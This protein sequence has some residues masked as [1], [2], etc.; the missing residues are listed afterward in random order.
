MPGEA[1][2]DLDCDAAFAWTLLGDP[3]LVPEWIAGVADAEVVATGADGRP[4]EVRFAG[5]PSTASVGYQLA[6]TYDDAA[7]RLVWR[8]VGG[9]ERRVEGS[10]WLEP[11]E[12]GGCRFHYAL[13]TW[14]ADSLPYWAHD[15]LAGDTPERVVASFARFIA[16]RWAARAR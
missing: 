12:G 13:A 6:Y 3:R 2:I 9:D 16:R 1:I 15:S 11:L 8:T 7:R 4:S 5:M 10:A 14:N